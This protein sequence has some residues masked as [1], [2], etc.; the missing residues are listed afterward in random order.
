[1]VWRMLLLEA[2][3]LVRNSF[4][5]FLWWSLRQVIEGNAYRIRGHW[6]SHV[7]CMLALYWPHIGPLCP[8]SHSRGVP[9]WHSCLSVS[10]N[11]WHS[12]LTA[13]ENRASKEGERIRRSGEHSAVERAV[14]DES[15]AILHQI[16]KFWA[17]SV[18]KQNLQ[19]LARDVGK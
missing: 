8:V 5:C 15:V 18:N 3:C 19:L 4:D 2:R 12:I 11:N 10:R 7:D 6:L 16:D 9:K 14:S 17:S 13:T 1:M